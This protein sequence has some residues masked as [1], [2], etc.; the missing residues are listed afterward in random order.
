MKEKIL[1]VEDDLALSAGLCFELQTDHYITMAAYNC[2]QA[3]QVMESDRFDLVILDV[4]L[5][6]GS[7]MESVSYTH[8]DVYKRQGPDGGIYVG[9]GRSRDDSVFA[10]AESRRRPGPGA[11]HMYG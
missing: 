1:I 7:G 6:D 4:N 3:V 5:P 8:L 2:R 9:S 10:A 11:F